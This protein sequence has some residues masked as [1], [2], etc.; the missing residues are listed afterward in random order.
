M[1]RRCFNASSHAHADYGGRGVSMCERW[2]MFENFLEDV[3]PRPSP[4]HSIDRINNNGNYEPGNV[5]WATKKQQ[6]TNRRSNR[7]LCHPQTGETL[8]L[9]EWAARL[10]ITPATL[11]Y[12]LERWSLEKALSAKPR[13]WQGET[14]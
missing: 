6:A 9:S 13:R 5:R 8:L 3:G 4:S 7:R 1:K 10:G 2:E 11:H 14:T 12:R